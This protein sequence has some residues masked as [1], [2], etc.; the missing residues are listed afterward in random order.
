MTLGDCF[1]T[2]ETGK[3]RRHLWIVVSDAAKDASVA[4]VNVSTKSN[5]VTSAGDRSCDIAAGE[6]RS[7]SRESYLRCEEAR[8]VEG[9]KLDHLVRAGKLTPTHAASAD[10]VA[11]TQAALGESRETRLEVKTLLRVQGFIT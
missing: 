3:V 8:L 4:I 10:L 9:A 11:K 5:P 6:H 2:P 7:I 1:F